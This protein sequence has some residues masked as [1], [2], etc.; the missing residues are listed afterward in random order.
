MNATTPLLAA[1]ALAGAV[2]FAG[3][4][5]AAPPA[6]D[7]DEKSAA[8]TQSDHGHDHGDDH[9]TASAARFDAE[10]GLALAPETERAL[11]LQTAVAETRPLAARR[12][13]TATVFDPGPP[14]RASALVPAETAAAFADDSRVLTVS[15]DSVVALG[16][17][18]LVFAAPGTPTLGAS[19][20]VE[21]TP[22]TAEHLSVP[23]AAVLRTA[24]GV[25]VYRRHDGHWLRTPVETGAEAGGFTAITRGLAAGDTVAITAV[26]HLW[27]TEL[28]LTKGG[29]HSH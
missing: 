29:G 21:S 23:T 6:H 28:R 14:A 5:R 4:G 1:V 18:E 26:E 16:H 15:R 13:V 19:L 10:H 20:T 11:G 7:H 9:G 24:T 3:C 12:V 2:A 8:T 25:F 27:L 17:V 22:A